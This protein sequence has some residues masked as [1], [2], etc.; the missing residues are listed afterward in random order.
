[1]SDLIISLLPIIILWNIKIALRT[2]F[3]VFGLM[4]L[5]LM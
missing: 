3:L 5:G 1:M 4:S 2:K